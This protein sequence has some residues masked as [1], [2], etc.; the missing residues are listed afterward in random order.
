MVVTQRHL[1]R[2]GNDRLT[3]VIVLAPGWAGEALTVT[4]PFEGALRR[5]RGKTQWRAALGSRAG[6]N[7]SQRARGQ[8]EMVSPER[9]TPGNTPA[10]RATRHRDARWVLRG[11]TDRPQQHGKPTD[12]AADGQVSGQSTARRR[13]NMRQAHLAAVANL[14]MQRTSALHEPTSAPKRQRSTGSM[15]ASP[16]SSRRPSQRWRKIQKPG[17]TRHTNLCQRARMHATAEQHT[18]RLQGLPHMLNAS[19]PRE[20]TAQHS[21]PT[22]RQNGRR[23]RVGQHENQSFPNL[24][25]RSQ[26][27][28]TTRKCHTPPKHLPEMRGKFEQSR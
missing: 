20:R 4:A 21:H 15:A 16:R 2:G 5:N 18:Q 8:G 11:T 10:Q 24:P 17:Q 23:L 25:Q 26:M 3:H 22:W 6:T 12:L 13:A 14:N 19:S 1:G 27:P 7:D 9:D 28:R